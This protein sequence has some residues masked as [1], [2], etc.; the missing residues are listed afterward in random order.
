[1]T[2]SGAAAT[3]A[4]IVLASGPSLTSGITNTGTIFGSQY[5]I[6]AY[7]GASIGTL[8][9]NTGGQIGI[10]ASGATATV[11]ISLT[12]GANISTL[13]NNN[14]V[15][16]GRDAAIQVE[17]GGSITAGIN[18]TAGGSILGQ[19]YGIEISTGASFSGGIS[20][21]GLIEGQANSAIYIDGATDGI[22]T[23]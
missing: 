6:R 4:G 16:A 5:A 11:G 21:N 18:N 9:N 7:N 14:G 13:T 22:F 10:T 23:V 3:S 20:N 12:N 15:I 8:T 2:A 1:M 19:V 17:G